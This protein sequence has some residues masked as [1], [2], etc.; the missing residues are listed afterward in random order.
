MIENFVVTSKGH[1]NWTTEVILAHGSDKSRPHQTS[2]ELLKQVKSIYGSQEGRE[3]WATDGG[4]KI[5][6]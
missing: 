5:V 6:L 3:L 4:L 2:D 1:I